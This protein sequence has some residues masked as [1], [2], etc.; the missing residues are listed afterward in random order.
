MPIFLCSLLSRSKRY[1]F[2]R[3]STKKKQSLIF[4][5]TFPEYKQKE[6]SV[7]RRYK[8][9]AWLRNHL[10]DK[11][12]EKGKRLTL[13]NLPGNTVGSFVG[14]GRPNNCQKTGCSL[15]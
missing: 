13:A 6:F 2:F 15:Y 5:T 10:K 11:L 8:D 3:I 14:Y 1:L 12:N 4:K 7:R 9:F